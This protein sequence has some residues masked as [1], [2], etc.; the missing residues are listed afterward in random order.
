MNRTRVLLTAALA[1]APLLGVAAQNS[2]ADR[3]LLEIMALV[4]DVQRTDNTLPVPP[5]V[6]ERYSD[7]LGAV[8]TELLG[9][10]LQALSGLAARLAELDREQLSAE[11]ATDVEILS[12]Q[13]RDRVNELKYRGYLLPIGSR[14]G[15]HFGFASGPESRTFRTVADYDS[16]IA[17]L[18]SFPE[19]TRQQIEL[20]RE[21]LARGWVLPA[22]VL[23]D[24]EMTAG[25]HV[26]EAPE[27][28][29]FWA[30]FTRLPDGIPSADRE[31]ILRDG[32]AGVGDTIEGYRALFEFFRDEY[33]PAGRPTLGVADLPDGGREFY[34]HRVR[35]Y[36]TLDIS[37]EEVHEIGLEQVSSIRAAMEEIRAE[38]GFTGNWEAFLE[39]LRTD[40]QF[41]VD[42]SDEY[43][44]Y[45]SL[46]AKQ[47]EGHLPELFRELPRTPYGMRA[48]PAHV[49]PRHSA[50]YYDRG[51]AD[52]TRGGWVNINTSQLDQRPLWV[53]RALAYHE[54]VPGHHLQI[55]LLQESPTLS[56]FRRR[57]GSTVFTEGWGLYAEKL[58]LDVGLMDDP[59]DRFGMWS[60]QI[61]RAC[62]LV[63]DTGMHALGWTR[64]QA[65]EYMADSTGMGIGPVTAEIDRHITEPGQGLAYTMGELEITA[66]RQQASDRLGAEF[67]LREF[68]DVVLRGGSLPLSI[69]RARVLAW[70]DE[71]KNDGL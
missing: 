56:E 16:Y 14:Y 44:A 70:I 48:I 29:G 19:H 69:L 26:V 31:R 21:G 62:R 11:S 42:T 3:E 68:H 38:V 28:S 18:Q 64:A 34:E 43:L 13:L 61:W 10:E 36:T 8:S 20:M 39:F 55:M 58:G 40:P 65:I 15:F 30:P 25:Q 52:G 60:Y 4:R 46:A 67:D 50:G 27:S 6:D 37:P 17:R 57:A 49:A 66:L 9:N 2:A 35:R 22:A 23:V 32:R 5:G 53:A 12:L 63:V 24:Y 71:Q 47:M 54:G 1:A 41:Y 51:N 33:V 7:R 45:V 59:Y